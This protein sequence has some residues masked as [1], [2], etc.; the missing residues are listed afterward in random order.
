MTIFL[1]I[2]FQLIF[3]NVLMLANWKEITA[4]LELASATPFS[5]Y[6][7]SGTP[8]GAFQALVDDLDSDWP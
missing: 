2:K 1:G 7:K 5:V 6:T 3:A 4:W 8:L